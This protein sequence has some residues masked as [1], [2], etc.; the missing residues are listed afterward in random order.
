MA[1]STQRR[2]RLRRNEKFLGLELIPV[3]RYLELPIAVKNVCYQNRIGRTNEK[4]ST[5]RS[6][7]QERNANDIPLQCFFS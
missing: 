1:R 3:Y 4:P 2:Q 6:N 7:Y 5:Y